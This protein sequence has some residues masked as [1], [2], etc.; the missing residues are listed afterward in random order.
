M[1]SSN[2]APPPFLPLEE[3]NATSFIEEEDP[4]EKKHSKRTK[5]SVNNVKRIIGILFG[6][7]VLFL[8]YDAIFRPPEKRLIKPDASD[9]FLRWV[10]LHPLRGIVAFV[11]VIASAVI[12]LLPVGTPLT[13]GCGFVYKSAYGWKM[14]FVIATVVSMFGSASG[15]ISCFLLGRYLM[16][17][18]V[19]QWIRKYP[20]FVAID[21]AAAE[22]GLKILAML[23]LTPIAPLGPLSYMSGTTSMQLS[24]FALAKIASLPIIMLY[25]F[26]G[27]SAGALV[28]ASSRDSGHLEENAKE[29][30]DNPAFLLF[31][32]IM[33]A[34]M[35][36]TISVYIK[37][38]LFKVRTE[39]SYL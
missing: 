36:S 11:V 16:R 22:H 3:A 1:T 24:H 20:L 27:A 32:I 12:L 9:R 23:Y 25:V 18:H 34:V 4:L 33:S 13:I 37:K 6:C 38:E 5:T 26:I 29:L 31:G 17:D 14:G 28:A 39:K 7:L 8:L 2:E 19:R 10:Q 21:T 35:I 30:E 15:A